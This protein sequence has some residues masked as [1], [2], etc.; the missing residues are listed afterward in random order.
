LLVAL[1]ADL[2]VRGL[3]SSRDGPWLPSA[4]ARVLVA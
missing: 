2:P 3:A 4:H 1:Q